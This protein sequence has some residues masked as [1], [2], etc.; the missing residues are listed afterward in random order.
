MW[1]IRKGGAKL[2]MDILVIGNGFDLEHELPTYY[3][4]FIDFL[5]GI[6]SIKE[7][8]SKEKFISVLPSSI[9]NKVKKYLIKS[10]S[11]KNQL[12]V[13][14]VWNLSNKN[15]W[16]IYFLSIE[17]QIGEGWIDF[18]KEISTVIQSLDYM[19]KY[20]KL[21][22]QHPDIIVDEEKMKCEKT[23]LQ[24]IE[25]KN[26]KQINIDKLTNT[27]YYK[28]IIKVLIDDLNDL[29][30]ALEIYIDKYINNTRVKY[31]APDIINLRI[32]KVL[33]FNYSSTYQDIYGKSDNSSID[34]NYIH[35]KACY[36]SKHINNMVLGIDEYL[37]DDLKDNELDFIQ[38]K[39]YFQRIYKAYAQQIAN[40]VKVIGQDNLIK[41]VSEPN[42]TIVF[43]KQS[44]R[45]LKKEIDIIEDSCR[46][47]EHD[48]DF[49]GKDIKYNYLD[50]RLNLGS[51]YHIDFEIICESK[52]KIKG[53][54]FQNYMD[55]YL[56]SKKFSVTKEKD[57]YIL[58]VEELYDY[59]QGEVVVTECWNKC[60]NNFYDVL[61]KIVEPIL[62]TKVI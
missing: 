48:K 24:F 43:K 30:R 27:T 57:K 31:I 38:F 52:I 62:G 53:I 34:Y 44:K 46:K 35:G 20:R 16:I 10:M 18:E 19:K 3:K 22:K 39:K 61:K 14:E 5:R 4:D 51:D 26:N 11:I 41:Q 7:E 13:N 25:D 47:L 6:N 58:A 2:K 29:I 45:I 23:I 8:E 37:D 15:I 28:E 60:E 9:N 59:A 12:I 33:S 54:V 32:N 21:S 56:K 40:L 50:K 55:Q 17:D 1:I 36:R 49:I 42:P